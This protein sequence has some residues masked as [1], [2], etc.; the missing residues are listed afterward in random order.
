ML[1]NKNIYLLSL[2]VALGGIVGISSTVLAQAETQTEA[3]A[4]V[5]DALPL[6]D[7]KAFT[8]IFGQSITSYKYVGCSKQ[9]IIIFNHHWSSLNFCI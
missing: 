4:Q 6:E 1:K 2:G 8:E 5:S 3:T 9:L 7:L